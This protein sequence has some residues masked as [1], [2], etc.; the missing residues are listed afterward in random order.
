MLVTCPE[1]ETE[2]SEEANPCPKCGLPNA[3]R[4]SIEFNT[5]HLEEEKKSSNDFSGMDLVGCTRCNFRGSTYSK[6]IKIDVVR[7]RVGVGYGIQYSFKCPK[8]GALAYRIIV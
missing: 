5:K 6:P 4:R 1:C 2:I 8:C 3:G 7:L